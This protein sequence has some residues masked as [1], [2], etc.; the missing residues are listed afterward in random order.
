MIR[1]ILI[2]LIALTTTG[3]SAEKIRY[4]KA[5]IPIKFIG[6]YEI[7]YDTDGL[8][9]SSLIYQIKEQAKHYWRTSNANY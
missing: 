2:G 6:L 3:Y 4:T 5:G 8:D 7:S 1:Y 9:P